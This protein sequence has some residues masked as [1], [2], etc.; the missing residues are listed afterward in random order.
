MANNY[1]PCGYYT[2]NVEG[3]IKTSSILHHPSF[4]SGVTIGRGYDMRD[5]KEYEIYK[6]LIASGI[7]QHDAN[8]IKKAS[9]LYGS[10]ADKFVGSYNNLITP[11]TKEKQIALFKLSYPPL[12]IDTKRIYNNINPV[13]VSEKDIRYFN[14]TRE[15]SK[16]H[17]NTTKWEDL[18]DLL[19]DM[20]IDLRYQGLYDPHVARVISKND[21]E[22]LYDFIKNNS[23]IMGYERGRNRLG[24]LRGEFHYDSY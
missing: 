10:R 24:Y 12:V 1:I 18:N 6:T 17:W 5:K 16:L 3:N 20:A 9:A 19:I 21:I 7:S 23:I 8:L 15:N 11:L 22:Y 4:G 14:K 13:T 2:F